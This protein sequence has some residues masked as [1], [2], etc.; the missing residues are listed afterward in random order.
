MELQQFRC[1]SRFK[2]LSDTGT[3]IFHQCEKMDGFQFI[4]NFLPLRTYMSPF[5]AELTFMP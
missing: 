3:F 2:A 4:M 1:R 5:T